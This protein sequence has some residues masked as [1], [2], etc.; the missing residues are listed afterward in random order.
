MIDCVL[1]NGKIGIDFLECKLC[2]YVGKK[3][4]NHIKLHHFMTKREYEALHGATT[5]SKTHDTYVKVGAVNANWIERKKAAGE[6]L[7]EY[8]R[9][10][11]AAVSKSI[12][13]NHLERERRSEQMAKNNRTPEARYKAS[14]TA[15]ITSA[16]PE[17]LAR[18]T[19]ALRKW[20]NENW[21]EFYNKCF[22]TM[23]NVPIR[24]TIPERVL[25]NVLDNTPYEFT[26]GQIVKSDIF[27]SLNKSCRRQ[28][29]FANVDC[30]LYVEFDGN[31]H[32]MR[33]HDQTQEQH[34]IVKKKDAALDQVVIDRG[35]TLIRISYDQFV[36]AKKSSVTPSHFKESCLKRLFELLQNPTPG[37]H[38]IGEAY[39]PL[40]T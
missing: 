17:V 15:K 35:W 5:C 27:K 6:D 22:L 28:V 39:T 26:Y 8:K 4:T 2:K 38:H 33:R 34:E 29:D 24:V 25:Q 12:M 36:Y 40:T 13:S 23:S 30:N 11:G 3:L 31:H 9:K 14:E 16:R 10:M 7:T 37:V 20:R 32:F 21:E 19:E 1:K 18:R